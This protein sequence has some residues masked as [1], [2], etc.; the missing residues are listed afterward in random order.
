MVPVTKKTTKSRNS[1]E[2]IKKKLALAE[3]HITGVDKDIKYLKMC[4]Y[5]RNGKGKTTFGA[6]GPK[7]IIL[8]CNEQ[9]TP[10]IRHM[11]DV[12]VFHV[13]T[14][15]DIDLAYWYLKAGKHDRLTVVIDSIT[16]LENLCMKF[17][18]GDEASR[19]PTRDPDTPDKRAYGKHK[20]L[21]QTIILQLR[22]LNMNVIFLAQERREFQD[23]DSE[24]VPEVGP[25]LGGQARGTLMD[26]VTIIGRMYTRPTVQKVKKKVKGKTKVKSIEVP[27]FRMLLVNDHEL[28]VSKVN[29][30]DHGLP[31]VMRDPTIP[32][33]LAS[34]NKERED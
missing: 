28:Y 11:K 26:C 5:A 9:G 27:D 10:S 18:L 8:D 31:R 3:S 30:Q 2:R 17:I 34:V 6:S 7:P 1:P 21:M 22:N 25:A 20:E 19:D 16:S 12:K 14:W 15:T 23:E 32:K 13:N 24:E 33:I 29:V 4:V